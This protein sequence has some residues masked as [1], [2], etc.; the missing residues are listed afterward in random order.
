MKGE[1]GR[2]TRAISG[3]LLCVHTPLTTRSAIP[4]TS[5]TRW[6]KDSKVSGL[7][8]LDK[9]HEL[10]MATTVFQ[11]EPDQMTR[12]G[13]LKVAHIGFLLPGQPPVKGRQVHQ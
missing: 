5:M 2:A 8:A 12:P 11:Q 4:N 3:V 7:H 6:V 10:D 13:S 9:T 1:E